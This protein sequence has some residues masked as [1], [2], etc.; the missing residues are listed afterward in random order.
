MLLNVFENVAFAQFAGLA[1][2]REN[3]LK[4][5]AASLHLAGSGPA[6]FTLLK[7]EAEA[8]ELHNHLHRQGMKAFLA[9]T[10]L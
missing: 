9:D 5:G 6:L 2:C 4:L 1:E 7:D 3:I 8:K 10:S